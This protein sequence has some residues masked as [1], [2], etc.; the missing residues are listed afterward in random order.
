MNAKYCPLCDTKKD[1]RKFVDNKLYHTHNVCMSCC[2][3]A[4]KRLKLLTDYDLRICKNLGLDYNLLNSL[5]GLTFDSQFKDTNRII[6]ELKTDPLEE[7]VS[8]DT[9]T[10]T[11]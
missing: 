8:N 6:D 2:T 3:K 7:N 1:I 5:K 11:T 9:L 4:S 10:P